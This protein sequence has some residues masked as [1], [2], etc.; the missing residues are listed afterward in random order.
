MTTAVFGGAAGAVTEDAE[1]EY[2]FGARWTVTLRTAMQDRR[3][4]RHGFCNTGAWTYALDN[5][6]AAVDGWAGATLTD[7][8]LRS[9][10][11]T[12]VIT[13]GRVQWRR[14]GR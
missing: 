7:W 3:R 6:N 10:D 11:G 13:R 14:P 5:A 4:L 8:R 12:L 9:A 2:S 1:A